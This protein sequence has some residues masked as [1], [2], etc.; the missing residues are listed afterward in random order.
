[1]KTSRA[2]DNSKME[3]LLS[4]IKNKNLPAFPF[5]AEDYEESPVTDKEFIEMVKKGIADCYR[6]NVFQV[7][8]SEG[9]PG[10]IPATI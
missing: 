3:T 4:A 5:H 2:G 6:G 1:M 7:V 8:L 9:L 10:S